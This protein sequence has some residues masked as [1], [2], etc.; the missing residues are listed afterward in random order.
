M[1]FLYLMTRH[2]KSF[3]LK[4][5]KIKDVFCHAILF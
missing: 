5:L 4:E 3:D 2:K 1:G